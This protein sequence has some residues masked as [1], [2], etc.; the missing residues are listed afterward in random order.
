MKHLLKTKFMLL[1]DNLQQNKYYKIVEKDGFRYLY[2]D[3][4]FKLK[5]G[6]TDENGNIVPAILPNDG[7]GA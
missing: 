3:I 6:T 4:A 1:V 7:R 5:F 2:G